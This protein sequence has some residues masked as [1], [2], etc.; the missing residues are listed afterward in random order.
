MHKFGPYTSL[1][2]NVNGCEESDVQMART[3]FELEMRN[4]D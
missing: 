3:G 2:L 1:E 4:L